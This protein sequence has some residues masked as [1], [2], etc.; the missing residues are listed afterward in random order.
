MILFVLPPGGFFVF[1]LL[2]A[3]ANKLTGGKDVKAGF[4]CLGC[5]GCASGSCPSSSQAKDNQNETE[6]EQA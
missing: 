1:G 4:D 5:P 6:V 2:I 3:L